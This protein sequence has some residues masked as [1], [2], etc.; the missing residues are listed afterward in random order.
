MVRD[1]MEGTVSGMMDCIVCPSLTVISTV[2]WT[3]EWVVVRNDH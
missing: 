3:L 1:M 2:S